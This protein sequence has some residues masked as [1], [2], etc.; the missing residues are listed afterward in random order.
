MQI[1]LQAP[2]Q[3]RN[4]HLRPDMVALSLRPLSLHHGISHRIR[5]TVY[6]AILVDGNPASIRIISGSNVA[7]KMGI[8]CF[9]APS[10]VPSADNI[11]LST[12][13]LGWGYVRGTSYPRSYTSV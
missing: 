2:T 9:S 1:D 8:R 3:L 5:A 10:L 4:C 11:R 7:F 13:R 6:F 12:T